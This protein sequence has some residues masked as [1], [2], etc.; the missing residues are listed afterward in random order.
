MKILS[1][2]DESFRP[3]GKVLEGCDTAE[4]IRAMKDIPLPE[5][6]TAYQPGIKPLEACAVFGELQDRAYGGMP[7]QLG[8]CWGHNTQLN[9]L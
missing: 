6:G 7:I 3:Y 4:L 8:M 1:V 5:S 9:C 2:Y